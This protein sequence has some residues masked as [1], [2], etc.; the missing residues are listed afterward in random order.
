MC[1]LRC[2]SGLHEQVA[3]CSSCC[4]ARSTIRGAARLQNCVLTGLVIALTSPCWPT[5]GDHANTFAEYVFPKSLLVATEHPLSPAALNCSHLSLQAA[6]P[7]VLQKLGRVLREK[8]SGDLGRVF[9]GT[10]KTRER[11]GVRRESPINQ[12]PRAVASAQH[13]KADSPVVSYAVA[14]GALTD[15][16]RS[17]R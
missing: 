12:L 14:Q 4:S 9:E 17:G 13:L 1:T 7:N 11:L 3:I 15:E 16:C 8:A 10:T 5:G 6:G 2:L